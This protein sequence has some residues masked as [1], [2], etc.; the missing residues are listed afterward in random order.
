[1]A[2]NLLSHPWLANIL[3]SHVKAVN[4]S[5]LA[6][7]GRANKKT[8]AGAV[9]TSRTRNVTSAFRD[10][11]EGILRQKMPPPPPRALKSH[12]SS[13]SLMHF[14]LIPHSHAHTSI[15]HAFALFCKVTLQFWHSEVFINLDRSKHAWF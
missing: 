3:L 9:L 15:S 6:G 1:M 5:V 11:K 4:Q 14:N 2:Q 13:V 12:A 8:S 10:A 7:N